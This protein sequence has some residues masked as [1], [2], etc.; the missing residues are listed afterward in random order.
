MN[1]VEGEP[2][3]HKP[4]L[5]KCLVWT[6]AA[7]SWDGYGR[8][9]PTGNPV[10]AHRWSYENIVGPIPEG[11]SIDHLCHNRACVNPEHLEPVTTA[12]NN[13]RKYPRPKPTHRVTH[14]PKGHEYTPENTYVNNG[15][16]YCRQ[17]NLLKGRKYET[18]DPK[19]H[20]AHEAAKTHCKNGHLFDEANTTWVKTSSGVGRH[21]K[22]CDRE[23]RRITNPTVPGT[24][25][26]E[27]TQCK[28]GHPFS[29]T[30]T[31]IVIYKDGR[32]MRQCRIC[33]NARQR[34]YTKQ[35]SKTT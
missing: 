34:S 19:R 5:G 25:Q 4:E 18:Y 21:C 17:C 3:A 6:N 7:K 15:A 23:R 11:M 1:V 30:N 31:K 29:D 32:Q 9:H 20:G 12:V 26:R 16:R 14:C 10:Q 33:V 22:T 24:Y 27:K 2:P 35:K 28:Y 13:A 8:F